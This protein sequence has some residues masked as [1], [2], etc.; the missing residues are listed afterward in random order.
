MGL[1][2]TETDWQS[3]WFDGLKS[4]SVLL[5]MS[6]QTVW[7]LDFSNKPEKSS[8]DFPIEAL[9]L[10]IVFLFWDTPA[11]QCTE[12]IFFFFNILRQKMLLLLIIILTNMPDDSRVCTVFSTRRFSYR[13]T[14]TLPRRWRKTFWEIF[15]CAFLLRAKLSDCYKDECDSQLA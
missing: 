2:L 11:G 12:V 9:S 15:C 14:K 4:A 1:N 13:N 6:R 10:S 5:K 3:E 7:S 8:S